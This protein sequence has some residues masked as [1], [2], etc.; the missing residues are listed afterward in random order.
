[1]FASWWK[2]TLWQ[3][4]WTELQENGSYHNTRKV[5]TEHNGNDTSL[6]DSCSNSQVMPHRTNTRKR[7]HADVPSL[8]GQFLREARTQ[9]S[10]W[11]EKIQTCTASIQPPMLQWKDNKLEFCTLEGAGRFCTAGKNVQSLSGGSDMLSTQMDSFLQ[12]PHTPYI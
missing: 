12:K 2:R 3:P 6:R 10:K 8:W 5:V 4:I 1:M 9:R 7:Q 11:P